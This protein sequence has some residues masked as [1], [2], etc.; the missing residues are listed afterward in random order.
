MQN[1]LPLS[2]A[3]IQADI[4]LAE[5]A[6][7]ETEKRTPKAAKYIK[8]QAGYHLQQATEKMI[9]IQL[10]ASGKVLDPAKIYKHKIYDLIRYA[11]SIGVAL[12]LPAYIDRNAVA[13]SDWEAEGRYDI[14]VTVRITQIKKCLKVICDWYKQLLITMP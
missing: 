13:I 9:K 4:F 14:H 5:I 6:V 3:Q 1:S 7:A 10:Y 8:G 12:V 2:M 11:S